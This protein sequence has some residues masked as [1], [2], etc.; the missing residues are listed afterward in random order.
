[1]ETLTKIDHRALCEEMLEILSAYFGIK[2]PEL[3]W[4]ARRGYSSAYRYQNRIVMADKS[5]KRGLIG[6]VLL[7]EFSHILTYCRYEESTPKGQRYIGESNRRVIRPH[8]P[9]FMNTLLEVVGIWYGEVE[10]YSW[11]HEYSSIAKW[12]AKRKSN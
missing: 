12:Y 3:Q 9:E 6:D 2:K 4:S 8:G 7:H 10:R 11:K 1:M 5:N